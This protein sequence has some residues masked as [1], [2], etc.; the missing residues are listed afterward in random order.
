V[1]DLRHHVEPRLGAGID[2]HLA[3]DQPLEPVEAGVDD[4]VE[5]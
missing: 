4:A 2:D 3:V 5:R 1:R